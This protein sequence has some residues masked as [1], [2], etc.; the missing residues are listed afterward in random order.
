MSS[1]DANKDEFLASFKLGTLAEFIDGASFQ[2]H[3]F[4]TA[5]KKLTA[6]QLDEAREYAQSEAEMVHELGHDPFEVQTSSLSDTSSSTAPPI[7]DIESQKAS[8]FDID[9]GF[10]KLQIPDENESTSGPE[11]KKGSD[12]FLSAPPQNIGPLALSLGGSK[13]RLR[14]YAETQNVLKAM[15]KVSPHVFITEIKAP[16]APL[17]YVQETTDMEIDTNDMSD[18]FASSLPP[19]RRDEE[20]QM[21][22]SSSSSLFSLSSSPSAPTVP[23]SHATSS[24]KETACKSKAEEAL[25]VYRKNVGKHCEAYRE[26]NLERVKHL[27]GVSKN[28]QLTYD[29]RLSTT[30]NGARSYQKAVNAIKNIKITPSDQQASFI[31]MIFD[32]CIKLIYGKEEFNKFKYSLMLERGKTYLQYG[33]LLSCPRQ[34][35]KSTTVAMAI[36]ALLYVCSGLRVI[37]VANTQPIASKL[38]S[39]IMMFFS[40]MSEGEPNRILQQS[41]NHALIKNASVDTSKTDKEIKSSKLYNVITAVSN[42][43][44]SNRGRSCDLLVLDEAEYIS[45]STMKDFIAPIVGSGGAGDV[46]LVALSTLKGEGQWLSAALQRKDEQMKRMF[47]TMWIKTICEDCERKGFLGCRHMAHIQPAW[48]TG[49]NRERQEVLVNNK[50]NMAQEAMGLLITSQKGYLFPRVQLESIFDRPCPPPDQWGPKT[51]MTFIDPKGLSLPSE[52]AAYSNFAAVTVCITKRNEVILIGAAETPAVIEDEQKKFIRDYFSNMVRHRLFNE[53]VSCAI[54]TENNFAGST[55]ET[56]AT[57]ANE[58]CRTQYPNYEVIRVNHCAEK[59]GLR[60]THQNKKQAMEQ[61]FLDIASDNVYSIPI[62]VNPKQ[63]QVQV[64]EIFIQQMALVKVKGA[65]GNANAKS[66]GQNDDMAIAFIMC[67]YHAKEFLSQVQQFK[68]L[69]QIQMMEEKQK[70]AEKER[71]LELRRRTNQFRI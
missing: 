7:R 64:R 49:D 5:L 8:M 46:V 37:V 65:S 21:D 51:F 50:S 4:S 32:S 29:Q 3:Q 54:V 13:L 40:Q 28:E 16:K 33:A 68:V 15:K 20:D 14:T 61:M 1:D 23:S 36:A 30:S 12:P 52:K 69:R 58:V 2:P 63:E 66:A 62:L 53:Q 18:L 48:N 47:Y 71:V 24:A 9:L 43:G 60:T 41:K 10:D 22:S 35:G 17:P 27:M 11:S 44:D 57:I 6:K 19:P 38:L 70:R 26:A 25:S 42:S 67:T 59:V 55:G 34:F 31:R 45:E 39:D 56:W